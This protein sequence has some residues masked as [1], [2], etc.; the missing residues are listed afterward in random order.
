MNY[1]ASQR[2]T[3]PLRRG[4]SVGSGN[5]SSEGISRSRSQSH[6]ERRRRRR[7]SKK[8]KD[9]GLKKKLS[10]VTHLLKCLD[11]VVF[12]EL[13]AMYYME[14]ATPQ[15][16]SRLYHANNLFRCSLFRFLLRA[17]GQYM[18]LS[19]K[20]EAFPF[21]MPAS[22]VHVLLVVIPNMLSILL[23]MLTALP[24]GPDYHR[25]Y[26]HGGLIIDFVGQR[27]STSRLYYILAD[28]FILALQCVMLCIHT[29]REKLRLILKT[30]RPLFP[31]LLQEL[32]QERTLEQLD[33]EERGVTSELVDGSPEATGDDIEMQPLNPA[34]TEAGTSG[35]AGTAEAQ[36]PGASG[37][38]RPTSHLSDIMSSGNGVLGEYHVLHTMRS[39]ATEFERTAA[40]SLRSFSYGTTL[41]ALQARRRGVVLGSSDR[42]NT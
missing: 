12:A 3:A 7:K 26:Q 28:I 15:T 5:R 11:L 22:R 36:S 6:A 29:E 8:R 25:G 14:Y 20:D 18:Y 38:D 10:F 42:S 32:R 1:D 30:F 4:L 39:A 19:P 34:D 2:S 37:D 27:P 21:L 23:H 33:A 16:N 35:Q 24:T 17:A 40:H 9:P 13:S 41:A 31:D